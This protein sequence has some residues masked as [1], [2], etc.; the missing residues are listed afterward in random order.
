MISDCECSAREGSSISTCSSPFRAHESLRKSG[1]KE[2]KSWNMGKRARE[3]CLLN[4]MWLVV[5]TPTYSICGYLLKIKPIKILA[6]MVKGL[7]V[8]IIIKRTIGSWLLLRKGISIFV[9]VTLIDCPW[10]TGMLHVHLYM[11][12]EIYYS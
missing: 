9:D 11:V 3:F 8:S 1:W 12:W 6:L 7:R 4:R 10:S 2:Y 5:Y